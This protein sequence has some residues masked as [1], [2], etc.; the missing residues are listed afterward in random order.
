MLLK[1]KNILQGEW[2]PKHKFL[3]CLKTIVFI[4]SIFENSLFSLCKNFF[5]AF[6]RKFSKFWTFFRNQKFW[7][8]WCKIAK[9][10]SLHNFIAAST[11]SCSWRWDRSRPQST[12]DGPALRVRHSPHIAPNEGVTFN[13]KAKF[14]C[15]WSQVLLLRS[16][17]L[18]W[19]RRNA[20]IPGTSS[21][22]WSAKWSP[23]ESTVGRKIP[24]SRTLSASPTVRML[25]IRGAG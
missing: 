6:S 22:V 12:A 9:Q 15:V 4:S 10:K 25:V 7:L 20:R 3:F 18:C 11:T 21:V 13:F 17:G 8:K 1:W 5:E 24:P 2:L 19:R 16:V 23:A 14:S